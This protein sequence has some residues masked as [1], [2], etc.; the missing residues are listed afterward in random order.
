MREEAGPSA[1]ETEQGSNQE[2][3]AL[4]YEGLLTGIV[5]I[6]AGR[7]Q[8]GSLENLRRRTKTALREIERDAI[9][10]GYREEDVTDASFAIVAFMDET[11][12]NSRDPSRSEWEKK[13]LQEELFG[14]ARA[15]ERFFE[16]LDSLH[17]RRDSSRLADVLE[18]S[19]LCLL[20]GYE[21]RY[22]VASRDQLRVLIDDLGDRIRSI[23]G[24]QT[25]LSPDG[26][27]SERPT[28][29]PNGGSVVRRLRWLALV[30]AV[31]AI[32]CFGALK[33]HLAWTTAAVVASGE[34]AL[35]RR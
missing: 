2:N 31:I 29:L 27:L 33:V 11:V 24:P 25:V 26:H 4:L 18:V 8:I 21:G 19:Y 30:S 17:A 28:S 16:R 22:G 13:S 7:Q 23:R 12:M 1:R 10:R 9:A 35:G 32:L 34:N 6:Q 15:G 20:L 5:R 14:E 3:L